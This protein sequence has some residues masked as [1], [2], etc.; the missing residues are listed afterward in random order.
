MLHPHVVPNLYYPI[1]FY[2]I[3]KKDI[4]KNIFY[5]VP[6]NSLFFIGSFHV[7]LCTWKQRSV[8]FAT[9]WTNKLVQ[10]T[11][12]V[13][14]GSH[15]LWNVY[16]V[17]AM[18]VRH[19]DN[20]KPEAYFLLHFNSLVSFFFS[21]LSLFF[22]LKCIRLQKKNW[23]ANAISHS[24]YVCSYKNEQDGRQSIHLIIFQCRSKPFSVNGKSSGSLAAVGKILRRIIKLY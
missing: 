12:T 5:C 15:W 8:S 7:L 17:C 3:N 22:T 20:H 18:C 14:H 21:C 19:N 4:F 2:C 11:W 13:P 23:F 10:M 16:H 9:Q 1:D 6:H 24:F